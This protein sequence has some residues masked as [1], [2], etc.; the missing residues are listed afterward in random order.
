MFIAKSIEGNKLNIVLFFNGLVP[1][2]K[3]GGTERVVYYLGLELMKLGHSV[4]LLVQGGEAKSQI[5][6]QVFDP[7]KSLNSQIPK[8]TDIVH[9][10]SDVNEELDYPVVFS[11]HGT[12][13]D[14]KK[15]HQNTIY[16]SKNHAERFGSNCY[17]YNGLDW[18]DYSKVNSSI[19]RSYY[20]FLGDASWRVKNVKGA[21]RI[22][23]KAGVNISVL[24][25]NRFNMRMGF[26]FTLTPRAR[27]FGMV[28][29]TMKD[30]LL[31]GSQGL[32]LPV[33]CHE[34]FGLAVIESLY[35]G[36]P[37]FTTPHGSLK[38]LVTE[39]VGCVSNKMDVLVDAIKHNSY[40]SKYC[41]EYANDNFSSRVMAASYLLKYAD[42]LN[43]NYLNSEQPFL[44]EVQ[45]TKFLDFE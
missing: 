29:G 20:H 5:K 6:T 15:F 28:G 19:K 7:K 21:I 25:G 43:N 22:A 31:N 44:Q 40:N 37:A 23:K 17:V 32:I 2:L 26:R 33:L 1:V 11:V 18:G 4:T 30:Q 35:Y 42:V 27:F 16:V 34:A 14:Q 45:K 3:Y 10:H 12:R 24:G 39:D 8:D 41:H 38:E 13:K 36:A 9:C